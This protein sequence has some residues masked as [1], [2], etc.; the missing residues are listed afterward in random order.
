MGTEGG[1]WY[2]VPPT[3]ARDGLRQSAPRPPRPE[4]E[5]RMEMGINLPLSEGEPVVKVDAGDDRKG[6]R[7][8]GGRCG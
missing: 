2:Q 6:G 4:A 1:T 3:A 5:I 7:R 8:G